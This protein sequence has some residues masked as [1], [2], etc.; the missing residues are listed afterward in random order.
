MSTS[1]MSA[2]QMSAFEFI[3]NLDEFDNDSFIKS[4]KENLDKMDICKHKYNFY[5]IDYKIG[6]DIRDKHH[7]YGNYGLLELTFEEIT[8]KI[9]SGFVFISGLSYYE[10]VPIAIDIR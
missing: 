4:D 3:D 1:E 8:K 10:I 2:N 6:E 9:F 7:D 5:K